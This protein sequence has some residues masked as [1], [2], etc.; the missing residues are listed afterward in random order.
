M[1]HIKFSG[2]QGGDQ[3]EKKMTERVFGNILTLKTPSVVALLEIGEILKLYEKSDTRGKSY[4]QRTKMEERK[5][6]GQ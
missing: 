1:G 4:K 2:V 5:E 3:R 6:Q